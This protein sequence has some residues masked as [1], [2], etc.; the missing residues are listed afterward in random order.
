MM[1]FVCASRRRHTRC[2]L[3]TGVQTWALPIW[4]RQVTPGWEKTEVYHAL[5]L[6]RNWKPDGKYPVIVEYAGNGV[7]RNKFGD[8]SEG[9]VEGSCLG[10]GLSGGVDFIWVCMPYVEIK[11][12]EKGN[13]IKWWG[14][15]EERSEEHRVR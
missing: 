11:N 9:T 15:I 10:Y 12:G 1:F 2:A 7:V 6:P 14:D 3:V 5:Y 4:V 13:A 8:V